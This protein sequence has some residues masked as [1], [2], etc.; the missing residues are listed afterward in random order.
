MR[1]DEIRVTLL[2]SKLLLLLLHTTATTV[3]DIVLSWVRVVLCIYVL[4]TCVCVC[5]RTNL[6]R[7]R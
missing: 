6:Y 4:R 2:V 5:V 1:Y 3:G 7:N